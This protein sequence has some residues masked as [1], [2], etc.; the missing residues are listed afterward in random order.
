MKKIVFI[1]ITIFSLLLFVGCG[2]ENPEFMQEDSLRN[3]VFAIH[4][5]VMPKMSDIVRLKGGLIELPTDSITEPLVKASHTQL[6]KS[7]D[8]MMNWM[9]NF[10][11]PEKL[12]E[13]KSHEEIMAYLQNE[14]VEIAKVRDEMNSS[15]E[16]AERIISS[17]KK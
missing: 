10:K 2:G 4:D 15:I 3:E 12:R 6:E 14:K 17:S 1:K 16:A 7:E 11:S 8:A 13:N 9:N 5:E